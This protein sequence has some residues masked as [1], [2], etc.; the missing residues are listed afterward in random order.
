MELRGQLLAVH[1]IGPETADSILLYAGEHPVFVVDAYTR[2]I[3]E[4]HELVPKKT[5]YE[6]LR[7]L[8]EKSL[9]RDVSLFNEFHALIVN[10]GKNFCRPEAP[11]CSTCPLGRYLAKPIEG[12]R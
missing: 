2:R 4:R 8:L 10:V 3:L 7:G 6:D 5:S 12:A 11:N 1:G 9:P